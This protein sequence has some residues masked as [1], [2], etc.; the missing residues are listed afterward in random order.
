MAMRSS[1][2]E[3]STVRKKRKGGHKIGLWKEDYP[4][5]VPTEDTAGIVTGLL[6]EICKC[7]GSSSSGI[8]TT[9]PCT[10]LHK[11]CIER[12]KKSKVHLSAASKIA[13]TQSTE[14]LLVH[15]EALIS[16]L[17][18]VYWLA[19]EDIAITTKYESLVNLESWM[20]ILKLSFYRKKCHL[21]Q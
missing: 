3:V 13:V 9:V 17:K 6:C 12:H 4:W 21:H 8:W 18:I 16:A 14:E 5:L 10:S 1:T 15:R 11:D 2:L 20:L 7:Q 19:K